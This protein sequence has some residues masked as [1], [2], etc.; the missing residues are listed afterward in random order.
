MSARRLGAAAGVGAAA[1]LLAAVSAP[2]AASAAPKVCGERAEIV[3]RLEQRHHETPNAIGL[4]SDGALIEV[5]V[6]PEGGWTFLLTY[7]DRPTCVM[8]VG[9]AW[10]P[11][12]L[13]GEG[14]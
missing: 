4:S 13:A 14:I 11:H 7:P 2:S 9:E 10:Q 1:V 3:K 5:L 12:M 8:A 6:S